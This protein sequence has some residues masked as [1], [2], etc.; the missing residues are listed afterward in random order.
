MQCLILLN[1]FNV[2]PNSVNS[3]R[4][5]LYLKMYIFIKNVLLNKQYEISNFVLE[6]I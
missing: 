5:L 3:I 4:K 6:D 1:V 2:Y